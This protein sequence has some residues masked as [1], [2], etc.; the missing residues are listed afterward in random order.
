ME[1][2]INQLKEQVASLNEEIIIIK[3]RM[4]V[5]DL[6]VQ[7]FS[8]A[9]EVMSSCFNQTN[10]VVCAGC[11]NSLNDYSFSSTCPGGKCSSECFNG[12]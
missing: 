4:L 11:G 10:S 2:E 8:L 12:L 6:T 3:K 9:F 1:N 5:L 7:K